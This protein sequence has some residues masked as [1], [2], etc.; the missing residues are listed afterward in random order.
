MK[1]KFKWMLNMRLSDFD[2]D[3]PKELIAYYPLKERDRARLLVVER[4][5]G[6][7]THRT[8]TDIVE[9][10][11]TDDLLV[12]NDTRVTKSRLFGRRKTGGAVEVLLLR[13]TEERTFEAMLRPAR[14][15]L[16]E[17]IYFNEGSLTA[18]LC[19]RNTLVFDAAR[20]EEIYAHG[21]MP[22]PPYIKRKAEAL[23][24]EYYQTVYAANDGAIAAPTA[25]L[26]FTQELLRKIGAGGTRI[27]YLT[28]HVGQGT[29]APVKSEDI[30]K[31]T[32]QKEWFCV[33]DETRRETEE[34]RH[35][36]GRIIAVGTTSAR[37]MESLARGA[38]EG[39]TDLF[40]Y[41]GYHFSMVDS[42]I[43]NFHLPRTTLFMLVCAYAGERLM[44]KAYQEAI[45]HRYRFYSYGDAM[46]IL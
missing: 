42:L 17:E 11:H 28:L 40:I 6:T 37:A 1:G 36:G 39:E 7:I 9:Y 35:R 15:R 46:C 14:L 44:N 45:T 43:T 8:F 20:D 38:T 34:A 26:H 3:L 29:F 10:L 23:D 5:A 13:K 30:R 16:N 19:A 21:V 12:L 41:P 18:R 33:P 24:T 2:Y 4:R 27:A 25:G 32:M 31:H 22:L